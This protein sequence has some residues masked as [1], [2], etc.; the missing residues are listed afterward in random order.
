VILNHVNG[1]ISRL[2]ASTW[3]RLPLEVKNTLFNM[4]N[5][6]TAVP[7]HKYQ[8]SFVYRGKQMD[9][10]SYY[11]AM[12]LNALIIAKQD[13]VDKEECEHKDLVDDA[14]YYA[15]LMTEE[16]SATYE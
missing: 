1:E 3:K 13:A 7:G 6:R 12:A 16:E 10:R 15:D 9:K 11:K 2:N 4:S 14:A 8:K 5:V